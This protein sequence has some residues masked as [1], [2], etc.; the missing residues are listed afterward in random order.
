LLLLLLL[1]LVVVV[2]V[3]VVVLA[4]AISLPKKGCSIQKK[5][6]SLFSHPEARKSSQN[7]AICSVFGPYQEQNNAI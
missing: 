7:T 3:V 1:V 6:G 4:K 5:K 2:V